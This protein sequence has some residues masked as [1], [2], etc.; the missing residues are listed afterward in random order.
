MPYNQTDDWNENYDG[1][2]LLTRIT[3]ACAWMFIAV[4]GILGKYS[5]LF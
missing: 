2:S 5:V 4:S 1:P 3:F